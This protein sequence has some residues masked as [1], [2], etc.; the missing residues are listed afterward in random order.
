M[1]SVA[2]TRA[3]TA[4]VDRNT[5]NLPRNSHIEGVR[6]VDEQRVRGEAAQQIEGREAKECGKDVRRRDGCIAGTWGEGI[7]DKVVGRACGCLSQVVF[8]LQGH[9]G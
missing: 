9:V 7:D 8:K 2:T 3:A 1:A 5:R 4:S 6:G